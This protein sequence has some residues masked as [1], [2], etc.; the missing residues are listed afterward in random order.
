MKEVA[1]YAVSNKKTASKLLS[2]DDPTFKAL[3]EVVNK[4]SEPLGFGKYEMNDPKCD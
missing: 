4:Y 1:D 3:I 2:G